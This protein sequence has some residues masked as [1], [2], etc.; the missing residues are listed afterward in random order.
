MSNIGIGG[1]EPERPDRERRRRDLTRMLDYS[2]LGLVFPIAMALGFLGGRFLGG[3]FGSAATGGLVGGAFGVVAG[4]YNLYKMT[5][6][7]NRDDQAS[8][9]GPR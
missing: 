3:L 1:Q 6:K 2:I 5:V 4:F 8:G 9:P 7:L